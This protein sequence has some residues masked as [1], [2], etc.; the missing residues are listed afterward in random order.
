MILDINVFARLTKTFNHL[1]I[2]SFTDMSLWTT[3][4]YISWSYHMFANKYQTP[5]SAISLLVHYL[6]ILMIVQSTRQYDIY[7]FTIRWCLRR[8]FSILLG[9]LCLIQTLFAGPGASEATKRS[10]CE[11]KIENKT[12]KNEAA[13]P[14][15]LEIRSVSSCLEMLS[16]LSIAKLSSNTRTGS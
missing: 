12:F 15:S 16:R 7:D 1:L 8:L 4:H 11:M 5:H 6:S 9:L 10:K 14:I 2:A 13:F 3:S